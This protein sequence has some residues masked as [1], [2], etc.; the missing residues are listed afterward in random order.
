MSSRRRSRRVIDDDDEEEEE[1]VVLEDTPQPEI[2]VDDDDDDDDDPDES[3]RKRHRA[4]DQTQGTTTSTTTTTN[5]NMLLSQGA[6]DNTQD[7]APA[8]DAER[9]KFLDLSADRQAKAVL[10]LTR[11]VLFK[12]LTGEP[13][14]RLKLAKEAGVAELRCTGA[15]LEQV[16]TRLEHLFA[17]KLQRV[18][19]YLEQRRDFPA[20][21]RDRF[22]LVNAAADDAAG[23]H[24]K[25]MLARH[26]GAS[27]DRGLLMVVLGLI[28]CQGHALTDGARW[29]LDADLYRGL[30]QLDENVHAA[31]P[32][33]N[34]RHRA[35]S[36]PG[37][38]DVDSALERF[39]RMDYLYKTKATEQLINLNDRASDTSF[40]YALGPRA[41][42]EVGERQVLNFCAQIR[43]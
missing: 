28:Y 11:L 23:T 19:R 2:E 13:L 29:L 33:S 17:L 8:R 34:T 38:P 10:D 4:D 35:P 41:A 21:C 30:H 7:L 12:G 43:E 24:A 6:P 39:V 15:V 37:I 40:F 22:Y 31:P 25:A 42:V 36:V 20:R 27:L 26:A 9:N 1:A 32:A 3:P 16:Q 18:P 5:N 14:D